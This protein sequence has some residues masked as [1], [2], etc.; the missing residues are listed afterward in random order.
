MRQWGILIIAFGLNRE[1]YV[2]FNG[3]LAGH[4]AMYG[5]CATEKKLTETFSV[6]SI[7]FILSDLTDGDL[8]N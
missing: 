8:R 5:K 7:I 6:L 2:V 3:Y 1:W 4:E